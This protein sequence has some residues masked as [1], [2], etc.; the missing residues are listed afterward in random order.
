MQ[1]PN[2]CSHHFPIILPNL[3]RP[4][5]REKGITHRVVIGKFD[6][7]N[8]FTE[9]GIRRRRQAT[10]GGRGQAGKRY[11]TRACNIAPASLPHTENGRGLLAAPVLRIGNSGGMPPVAQYMPPPMSGAAGAAAGGVGMSATRLSVVSTMAATEA[12][13]CNALL[14]TLVGSM[15]PFSSMEP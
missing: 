4:D 3:R 2:A 15:M 1:A 6:I 9:S 10:T 5:K 13:F 14:V 12:A 7:Y 8:F 11:G